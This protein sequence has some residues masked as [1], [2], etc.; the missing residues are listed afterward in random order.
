M[1][2][3]CSFYAMKCWLFNNSLVTSYKRE[4]NG[5]VVLKKKEKK[6]KD[7]DILFL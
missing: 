1:F 6:K 2:D 4:Q 5:Y 7:R 3:G